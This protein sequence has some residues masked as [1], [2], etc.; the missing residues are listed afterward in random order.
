MRAFTYFY[1]NSY[2]D[3]SNDLQLFIY[4]NN[5]LYKKNYIY[6]IKK[7]WSINNNFDN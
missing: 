7:G 4:K 1:S 3:S 5:K 2:K 6:Y